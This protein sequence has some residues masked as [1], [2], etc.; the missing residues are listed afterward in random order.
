MNIAVTSALRAVLYIVLIILPSS[1]QEIF[2]AKFKVTN[3]RKSRQPP[4]QLTGS[5]SLFHIADLYLWSMAK[6]VCPETTR[7]PS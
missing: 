1:D 5:F 6:G 3:S 2:S 4:A 7:G